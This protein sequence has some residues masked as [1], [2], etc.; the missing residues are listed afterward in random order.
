[1]T[2]GGGERQPGVSINVRR[3]TGAEDSEFTPTT[4]TM[5]LPLKTTDVVPTHQPYRMT[6][7]ELRLRNHF[8]AAFT[9]VEK[10]EWAMRAAVWDVTDEMKRAGELPE[11]VIKRIKYIAAIPIAFHYRF[12]YRDGHS[13]L[14]LAVEKAT[15][16]CI[17]RYFDNDTD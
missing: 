4:T 13:R 14:T 5:S 10:P 2:Q 17:A 12:G 1:M 11:S 16:F 3:D 6:A 8:I 7:K 15:S 9:D